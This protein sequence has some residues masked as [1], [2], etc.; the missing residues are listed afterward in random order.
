MLTATTKMHVISK[1]DTTSVV[2]V[3]SGG[4]LR[5]TK[6][7]SKVTHPYDFTTATGQRHKLG[8]GGVLSDDLREGS[9]S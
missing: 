8:F 9:T 6:L 2:L 7:E 3:N 1:S 5:K 4:L